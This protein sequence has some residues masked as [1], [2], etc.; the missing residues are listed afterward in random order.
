LGKVAVLGQ[1]V[2]AW[3]EGLYSHGWI[4]PLFALG[5]M[6]MRWEPFGPVPKQERWMVLVRLAAGLCVRYYAA[7]MGS[8]PYDRLS[9]LPAIFG[10]FMLV[11]GMNIIRW[12]WPGLGFLIFMFFNATVVFKAGFLR[13]LG[14]VLCAGLALLWWRAVK[15]KQTAL[16]FSKTGR[17]K[18][19]FQSN[20]Y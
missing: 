20:D 11:G 13:W 14:L 12:A 7:W 6:W 5:L 15:D 17:C 9:F 8:P 18:I 19:C 2:A 4:V 1:K 16:N 10:V 3:N